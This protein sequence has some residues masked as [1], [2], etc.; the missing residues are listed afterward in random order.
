MQCLDDDRRGEHCHLS[1]T[2]DCRY[3]LEYLP[4]RPPGAVGQLIANYKCPPLLAVAGA[5]RQHYKERAI[6]Q[7]AAALRGCAARGFVEASTWVPVPPSAAWGEAGYDDRLVRTLR[8]AFTGYDLDLRLLL[9]Q[10]RSTQPDHCRGRRVSS[11]ALLGLIRLD[12]WA[13]RARPLRS[14]IVLFDDVLTTG[15]HYK[16]CEQ[17]LHEWLPCVPVCGWFIA[18]RALKRPPDYEK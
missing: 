7:I 14:R 18:R 1:A 17:R 16:C 12:A 11:T 3:L 2:D 13:M 9:Q 4:A 6:G 5:A 15:K 8:R 10:T